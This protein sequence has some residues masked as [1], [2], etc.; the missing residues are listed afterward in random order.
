[1]GERTKNGENSGKIPEKVLSPAKKSS[2]AKTSPVRSSSVKRKKVEL[3]REQDVD[4]RK[5][6]GLD[7]S[8]NAKNGGVD[9]IKHEAGKG[10]KGKDDEVDAVPKSKRLRRLAK[11][12]VVEDRCATTSN[13]M[14]RA[15][16]QSPPCFLFVVVVFA[17]A[18]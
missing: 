6:A 12:P 9:S 17:A 8:E 2:P 14:K 3:E 11:T 5:S 16:A 13:R 10:G 7:V 18:C 4:E 1:M 15:L